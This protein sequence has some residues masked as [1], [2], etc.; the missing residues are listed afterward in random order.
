MR[1]FLFPSTF[2]ALIAGMVYAQTTKTPTP[3][4]QIQTYI[5]VLT[6]LRDALPPGSTLTV[7]D[8]AGRVLVTLSPTGVVSATAGTNLNDLATT[9]R[10]AGANRMAQ[11]YTL[12]RSKTLKQHGQFFVLVTTTQGATQTLPLASVLHRE[13]Q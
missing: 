5:S 1:R 3:T 12:S 13:A 11:Q 9:V 10:V 2:L 4:Q 8:P 6:R 7:L